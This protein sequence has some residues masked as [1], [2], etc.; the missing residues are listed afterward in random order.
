MKKKLKLDP[1]APRYRSESTTIAT[2]KFFQKFF[3]EHPEWKPFR[4]QFTDAKLKE[5]IRFVNVDLRQKAID[6]R[7]GVYLPQQMGWIYLG[8]IKEPKRRINAKLSNELGYN[9]N[10][11][12]N[13]TDGKMLKIVHSSGHRSFKYENKDLFRFYAADDFKEHASKEFS[14]K[15]MIYFPME[16]KREIQGREQ[17]FYDKENILPSDFKKIKYK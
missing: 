6:N 9:V 4:K 1:K 10:Y 16:N 8:T 5:M 14:K 13:H 17:S 7:D 3:K 11:T 15:Y 12:N 2:A